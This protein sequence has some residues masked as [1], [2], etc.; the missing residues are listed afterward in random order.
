MRT[1]PNIGQHHNRTKSDDF[2]TSVSFTIIWLQKILNYLLCPD[3]HVYNFFLSYWV[4]DMLNLNYEIRK[5]VYFNTKK[6]LMGKYQQ[7]VFQLIS[8]GLFSNYKPLLHQFYR[9]QGILNIFQRYCMHIWKTDL[10]HLNFPTHEVM[11]IHA[12][13]PVFTM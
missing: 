8:R 7:L 11:L 2:A 13:I 10:S 4:F 5:Q 9:S 3:K 12:Y 1:S 6:W